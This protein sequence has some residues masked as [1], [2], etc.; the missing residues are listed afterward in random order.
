MKESFSLLRQKEMHFGGSVRLYDNVEAD[1]YPAHWNNAFEVIMPIENSY[2]VLV[3]DVRYD[4]LPD[5]ILIIPPG[6]VHEIFAPEY[7]RRYIFMIDQGQVYA[8]EGLSA[9]QHCF[10]PCVH[11]RAEAEPDLLTELH[12]YFHHAIAEY[13]TTA[14]FNA[15]ALQMWLGLMFTRIGRYLLTQGGVGTEQPTSRQER[16]GAVFLDACMYIAQH[17]TEKL[18][19]EDVAAYCGYSKYHFARAFKSY[20][21]ISFYDFLLRQRL[22]LCEKMLGD[23]SLPITEVAFRC[24]FGS[25]ASFNRVFKQHKQVT[26]SEYRRLKQHLPDHYSG[27]QKS[28]I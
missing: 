25:I 9:V 17:C 23:M 6:S 10:Y 22:M 18:T 2:T 7:G 16:A 20:T 19:L 3:G 26:P 28:N 12:S 24:G 15:S 4:V 21:G 13:C 27:L 5:D 1:D 8:V 14:L 11:L